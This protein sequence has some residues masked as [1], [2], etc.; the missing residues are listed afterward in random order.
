MADRNQSEA[1]AFFRAVGFHTYKIVDLH[2]EKRGKVASSGTRVLPAEAGHFD[3]LLVGNS[4]T[5]G[6]VEVK[7]GE[8]TRFPFSK[9]R[10]EQRGWYKRVAVPK[11]LSAWIFFD[12]G[13]HARSNWRDV[14][15]E[16][17]KERRSVKTKV[18]RQMPRITVLMP[19][20]EYLKLEAGEAKSLSYEEIVERLG[21]YILDY[22]GGWQLPPDHPFAKE[23]ERM[24]KGTSNADLQR[25]A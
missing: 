22:K 23:F 13:E 17:A 3:M 15:Q 12:V 5:G 10:D 1:T 4:A 8:A 21:L 14:W 11:N 20:G 25:V 19:F 18:K 24:L 7:A 2:F 16:I 9:V 6:V